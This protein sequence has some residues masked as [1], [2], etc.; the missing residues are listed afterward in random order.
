MS[1]QYNCIFL[2][3][4]PGPEWDPFSAREFQAHT[5]ALF[6]GVEEFEK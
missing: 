2:L 5:G 3:I 1:L 6:S 4:D